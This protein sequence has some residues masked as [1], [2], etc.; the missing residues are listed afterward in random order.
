MWQRQI[1][2]ERP[3]ILKIPLAGCPTFTALV[4]IAVG[5]K[6]ETANQSGLSHFLEHMFFKGT[7]KRPSTLAISS[8]LDAIGGEYNAFTS[9][10]YTGYYVKCA[11]DQAAVALDVLSDMLLNSQFSSEEID[12]ERGVIIEEINMYQDNPMLH[13][14]DVFE[15]TLY[16]DTPA[17]WDTAGRK[18]TVSAFQRDD[19]INYWRQN[20]GQQRTII[21]LAGQLPENIDSLVNKY[22]AQ[23]PAA[24]NFQDK[25]PVVEQQSQPQL[26]VADKDTDQLHLALGVRA[27]PYG[28]PQRLPSRLL[29]AIL[30]GSMSSRLFLQIRERQ[31][32]AYYVRTSVENYTDSGYLVTSAGIKKEAVAQAVATII[33]EYKKLTTEL[34]DVVELER[35][36]KF[37]SGRL[38]LG[39]EGSDDLAQWYARQQVLFLGQGNVQ[40]NLDTPTEYLAKIRAVTAEQ[41][42]SVARQIFVDQGLNLAIIGRVTEPDKL[43]AHLSFN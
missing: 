5:S 27:F 30:G 10:E 35:I 11:A 32:L 17:G 2:N 1:S 26:L 40:E 18:E 16:G 31:G 6:Y 29:A 9:K 38:I 21:C 39:L 33:A 28:H 20:Y 15:Q 13:L 42:Q 41:I 37:L 8:E 34:V 7:S 25:L 24:I 43:L 3:L 14:E 36:K 22:F 12:R 19:F 4:V 23:W